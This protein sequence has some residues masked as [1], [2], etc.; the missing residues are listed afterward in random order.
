MPQGWLDVP[1]NYLNPLDDGPVEH[2]R[3]ADEPERN[4]DNPVVEINQLRAVPWG[5]LQY[6][7]L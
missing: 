7:K 1:E 2:K 3:I 6:C 5:I 4:H